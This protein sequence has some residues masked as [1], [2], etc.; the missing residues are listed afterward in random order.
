MKFLSGLFL[1]LFQ[2][3][4][5]TFSKQSRIIRSGESG[6]LERIDNTE[7]Q[8]KIFWMERK[9]GTFHQKFQFPQSETRK[10]RTHTTQTKYPG[11]D[12]T[13]QRS[14]M[15]CQSISNHT[16]N[17][18][19]KVGSHFQHY[20]FLQCFTANMT[21][22]TSICISSMMMISLRERDTKESS[23]TRIDRFSKLFQIK[24]NTLFVFSRHKPIQDRRS[25]LQFE[26]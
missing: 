9:S 20:F 24:S 5:T 10:D 17:G 19:H 2:I 22:M 4:C 23:N 6:N 25:F 26:E 16:S 1:F 8:H 12:I 14:N 11:F 7:R 15:K 18:I 21:S 13:Q 3:F